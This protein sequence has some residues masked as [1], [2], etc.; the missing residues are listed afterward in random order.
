M[1]N[2]NSHPAYQSL[3]DIRTQLRKEKQPVTG[4]S[5]AA[6]LTSYSERGEEYIE[7]LRSMMKFNKLSTHDESINN[8]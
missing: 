1:Q 2:L 6:G 4:F 5:L 3:R 8:I 7:E